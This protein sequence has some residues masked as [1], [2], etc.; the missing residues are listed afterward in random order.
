[1][2]R[3]LTFGGLALERDD[4][5]APRLR[6]QRLA[7]LA[8][9]ATAGDRGT[10][11]ERLAA[12]FWPDSDDPRHSLR[13]ALYA[14]R[15]ELGTDAIVGD[16]VLAIDRKTLT[17]D[18]LEFRS[19]LA[20]GNRAHAASIAT[21][22][23]LN[24]FTLASC[25]EFE[26]WADEER[27]TISA[28]AT[29]L[30]LA[31]AKEADAANDLESAAEW[32]RRLTILDPLSGRFALGNLKALA[33]VGDRAGALAFARSHERV[34]R[35]ELEADADPEIRKL[36]AELR[37]LPSPSVARAAPGKTATI[38]SAATDS[39]VEQHEVTSL[40]S[41]RA[42]RQIIRRPLAIVI[43]IVA[44]VSLTTALS[45]ILRRSDSPAASGSP[46]YAV[47]MIREEGV[48]DTLRIG[49]VLTD[50]LA[51]NLARVAGLSV[52]ANSRLFELMLPGQDTLPAGYLDAARRAGA[53]EIL[54]GRLLSGPQW[55]LAMEIQRID[56]KT[57]LVK[58]GYRI[59]AA[60]RYALVDSMTSAIARDL[61]LDSPHGSIADATT[62]NQVAYRLYEEGLRAYNQYDEATALRLMNAALQEDSTFAMAAYYAARS[63]T[64][65]GTLVPTRARALRL[66]GGA[67]ERERLTITADLRAE[68]MDPRATAIAESLATK[69]PNDPRGH[70][71]LW[72]ALWTQGDWAGSVKAIE[73]AIALDSAAEP[74]GRQGCR[75]C[76]DYWNLAE[77]YL[78]WDSLAAAERT[79]NRALRLR[80]GWHGAWD[81]LIR[82]SAARGDTARAA[83][84][85]RRFREANPLP[86]SPF[87]FIQRDILLENY[88]RAELALQ[89][90]LE[91]PRPDEI[92]EALWLETIVLR[93]QGRIDE[94]LRLTGSHPA[95]SDMNLA[96][97]ALDAGMASLALPKL[98]SRASGDVSSMAL[99]LQARIRTWNGTLIGMALVEAGDTGGVRRL[100]DTVEY[101]GRHSLYGRDRRAH[102]YLRGMLLIAQGKD[103]DA[104]AQLRAAIHSPTN[105]F[106][107]VNYELGRALL[108]LNRPAEAVT[109]LR[110]ALH[111]SIDGS[112]LYVTRTDLHEALAQAF[113]KIGSRDSA[114]IHYRAVSNA[115][116][117]ADARYHARREVALARLAGHASPPRVASRLTSNPRP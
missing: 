44:L 106:T 59:A 88:D 12:L 28:A 77:T 18:L 8:V 94:A 51:T 10:S 6:P 90:Y 26:R 117:Q 19:A 23:F 91:S 61:E 30:L 33:S 112:N 50:M 81:I 68:D 52:V 95:P 48:P 34:V 86:V 111:G 5:P 45:T 71:F 108:R 32:W 20:S 55:T 42:P 29:K 107:R 35:R 1:M 102:H 25:P 16:G 39:I 49:G 27:A 105:G 83:G 14:L 53:T 9:L 37:A 98:R 99:S 84:Y 36:E 80:P 114:T 43:A 3:L 7:I 103:N 63:G 64:N 100:A 109:V 57:G 104:V 46:T 82:S 78:W 110:A 87:Y 66:A 69:Y 92:A 31:L 11:R 22:P 73:H 38:V 15:H 2:L 115:W 85:M 24:G 13:Q 75:L 74:A 76:N 54:Q 62:D 79:A 113:D 65:A 40:D 4:G 97:V 17:C 70:E 72:K 96:T 101:W 47:G 89:P 60:D 67:P 41:H 56:L 58:H 93:N 21:G 116:K